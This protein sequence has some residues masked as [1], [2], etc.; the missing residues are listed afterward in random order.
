MVKLYAD[1]HASSEVRDLAGPLVVSQMTRVELPAALWR[2]H[3]MGELGVED[4]RILIADFE[5]D[6]FGTP[7]EERRFSAVRITAEIL[8]EAVRLTAVHGLRAYGAVQLASAKAV[9]SADPSCTSCAVFDK[10]LR[11]AAAMEGFTPLPGEASRGQ[12]LVERLRG[13]SDTGMTTD[14]IMDLTRGE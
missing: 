3:R 7:G 11:A 10:N 8:E 5:A 2:K 14:E 1:E 13:K 12:N 9:R 4:T 6:Y